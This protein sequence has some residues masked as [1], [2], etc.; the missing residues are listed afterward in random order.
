M[1]RIVE[2]A[3]K[4]EAGVRAF[5]DHPDG[6][7]LYLLS[8]LDR[9]GEGRGFLWLEGGAVT[10]FAWFGV[11][12]N[13]VLAGEGATFADEAAAVARELE[14]SWV[15]VVG[16]HATTTR[17]LDRFADLSDRR[18]RLDRS[19]TFCVQRR[20]SLPDLREPGLARA[21]RDDLPALAGAAARMSAEDFEIDPW[22]IDREAVRRTMADK[23]RD[24]RA[25]VYRESDVLV[26][27]ADLALRHESGGQVEGVFT[28]EDRR[29]QGVATRCMAEIGHR[30]L[31]E[32]PLLTLHVASRNTPA[33]R[34]YRSAGYV[35]A[36]ELRLA[37]FPPTW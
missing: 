31:D 37:I 30:L 8:R 5:L 35:P 1:S 23:V 24:G 20:E 27:K 9:P 22:R 15:M 36:A 18:P 33:I 13:L 11:G 32:L 25:F 26:F 14:R 34:A 19:Q 7:N 16:P 28:V 4:E 6:V 10:G 3:P 2:Y 21:R 12:R 17:F 29:G